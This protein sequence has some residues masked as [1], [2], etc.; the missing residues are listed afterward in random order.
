M[1]GVVSLF[2]L[3]FTHTHTTL[4]RK[5]KSPFEFWLSVVVWVELWCR[6]IGAVL[7][8]V[9]L[10][11]VL[12][13]KNEER[14]F[15]KEQVTITSTPEH[16]GIRSASHAK[17]SLTQPLLL[18]SSTEN[19]VWSRYSWLRAAG[20]PF[21]GREKEKEKEEND[22]SYTLLLLY[23][24]KLVCVRRPSFFLFSFG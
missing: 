19:N 2:G 21:S 10:Y 8:V 24:R 14:K 15:A 11:F 17:T 5:K 13:G 1:E 3:S 12:W 18:P 23:V 7:I 6:I 9:G 4:L 20:A 22:T 16:S